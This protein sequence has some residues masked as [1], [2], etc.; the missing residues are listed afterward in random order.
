MSSCVKCSAALKPSALFCT[1]CGQKVLAK[2]TSQS[3]AS[4]DSSK[5]G[6][7]LQTKEEQKEREK[8]KKKKKKKLICLVLQDVG[9]SPRRE[10]G[11]DCV[12]CANK[13][14]LG[15]KFCVKC[16]TPVAGAASPM[17]AR[18]KEASTTPLPSVKSSVDAAPKSSVEATPKNLKS[19]TP[20]RRED[21]VPQKQSPPPV[22]KA[23]DSAKQSP[24]PG[25]RAEDAVKSPPPKKLE[26]AKTPSM[27]GVCHACSNPLKP[28]ALF[29]TKCGAKCAD[30]PAPAKSAEKD[31]KVPAKLDAGGSSNALPKA[32]PKPA[33][34]DPPGLMS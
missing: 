14:K 34:S 15:A 20:V 31:V 16:G 27:G 10:D 11:P 23:E 5:G 2:E 1:K 8:E 19:P 17:P 29:C 12:K 28:N 7:T 25:R 21:P 30:K 32:A 4:L 24:M 22:R 33:Q 9:L 13:L 6:E 18:N 3:A 26:D